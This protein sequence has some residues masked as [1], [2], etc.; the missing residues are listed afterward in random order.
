MM[1]DRPTEVVG[2]C[3]LFCGT[4]PSYADDICDG[5]LSDRVR[6]DCAVCSHG[7]RTCAKDHGVT[8]CKECRDFPCQRLL[9]FKDV[10]VV[11]R[12]SHHEHIVEFV[13]RQRE[14]GIEAWVRE[15]EDSNACPVCGT[16]MIWCEGT[17]RKCGHKR[18]AF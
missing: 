13:A 1:I 2:I 8:W 10:H 4:C 15:Q 7:F 9:D 17:C 5:C 16:L 6:G 11:N 18:E 12:I 3:G 14:I